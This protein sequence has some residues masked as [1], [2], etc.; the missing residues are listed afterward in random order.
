MVVM[1]KDVGRLPRVVLKVQE[2]GSLDRVFQG[3]LGL[4]VWTESRHPWHEQGCEAI[5]LF[6]N[7]AMRMSYEIL[8]Y[9]GSGMEAWGFL[10]LMRLTDHLGFEIPERMGIMGL[11]A[12]PAWSQRHRA[13]SRLRILKALVIVTRAT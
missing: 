9:V 5:P 12:L 2:G 13:Q 1:M 8:V 3:R 4:R 10:R 6:G 7:E 11:R